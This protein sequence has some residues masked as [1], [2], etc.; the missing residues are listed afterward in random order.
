MSTSRPSSS[1]PTTSN[2][3]VSVTQVPPQSKRAR[4]AD[5]EGD[6]DDHLQGD[7]DMNLFVICESSTMADFPINL[8]PGLEVN[9]LHDTCYD[10]VARRIALRNNLTAMISM[11]DVCDATVSR[12][13]AGNL[14]E[15]GNTREMIP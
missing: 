6:Q 4:E 1:S 12:A 2:P 5:D 8:V 15:R 11:V 3:A 13:V 7:I 10:L 14:L 9:A